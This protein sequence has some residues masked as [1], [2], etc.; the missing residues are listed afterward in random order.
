MESDDSRAA[1]EIDSAI[2]RTCH[3][4]YEEALPILY[5]CNT[6][7]FSDPE[8]ITRFRHEGVEE[9]SQKLSGAWLLGLLDY[10]ALAFSHA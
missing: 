10:I 3:K 2:L 5:G 8:D 4:V 9:S 7:C 1:Y 6:F